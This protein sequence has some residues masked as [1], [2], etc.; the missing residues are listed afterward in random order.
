MGL[1][2]DI[3]VVGVDIVVVVIVV[4]EIEATAARSRHTFAAASTAAGVHMDL[5]VMLAE[6]ALWMG[7]YDVVVDA[8]PLLTLSSRSCFCDGGG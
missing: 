1:G 4:V 6:Q 2:E 3:V 7:K 5:M 8:L